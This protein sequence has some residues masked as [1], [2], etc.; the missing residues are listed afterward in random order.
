MI[1]P[2]HQNIRPSQNHSGTVPGGRGRQKRDGLIPSK[3]GQTLTSGTPRRLQKLETWRKVVWNSLVAPP[4]PVKG[5]VNWIIFLDGNPGQLWI[6]DLMDI[7][8]KVSAALQYSLPTLL[9]PLSPVPPPHAYTAICN[10][11]SIKVCV[12]SLA[13]F[14]VTWHLCHHVLR[15]PRVTKLYAVCTQTAVWTPLYSLL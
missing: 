5:Q 15:I 10:A 11:D 7:Q 9:E 3:N 8:L 1:W 2:C 13:A 12:T 4:D 6:F 14:A